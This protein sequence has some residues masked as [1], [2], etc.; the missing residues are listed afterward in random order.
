MGHIQVLRP[1]AQTFDAVENVKNYSKTNYKT[2][3]A[4]IEAHASNTME[5][6]F[7]WSQTVTSTGLDYSA[8]LS[9]SAMYIIL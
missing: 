3:V 1:L 6:L 5:G 2:V 7:S 4:E 9:P 8:S